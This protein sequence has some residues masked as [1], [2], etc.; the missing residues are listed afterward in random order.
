[1]TED[2]ELLDPDRKDRSV[3]LGLSPGTIATLK[4]IILNFRMHS[5]C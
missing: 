5:H 4:E 1:M 2:E 3:T